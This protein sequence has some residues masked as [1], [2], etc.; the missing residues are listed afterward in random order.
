MSALGRVLGAF[1]P[2]CP[3][4][5]W[6]LRRRRTAAWLVAV[7]APL[8]ITLAQRVI[9]PSSVPP[10]ADLFLML[11]A[12]LVAALFGGVRPALAAV[13]VGLLAQEVVFGFPYASLDNHVPAQASVLIVWVAI[14]VGIGLLVDELR[15]LTDEQEAL[16]RIALV[17]AAGAVPADIFAA[18]ATELAALLHADAAL[19]A[20][21]EPDGRNAI[22]ATGG[23]RARDLDP[24]LG[25]SLST[26][27]TPILVEG[28]AW[29]EV[30]ASW[31]SEHSPPPYAE[32]R[33]MRFVQLLDAAIANADSREQLM[34]SRARLVTAADEARRRVVRD[35]HDG[36]QQR[37]VHVIGTLKLAQGAARNGAGDVEPL[38]ARA[39]EQAEQGN[40]E[41]RDLAHGIL[42]PALTQGGLRAGVDALVARLDLPVAVDV[43]PER[44]SVELEASGYFIVCEG[45]TNVIK[46]SHATHAGVKASVNDGLLQ[47]E[48]CDDGIGVPMLRVTAWLGWRTG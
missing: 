34:A 21:V 11:L 44:L 3:F 45:L 17:V 14:G 48:V 42:P 2:H 20:H 6:L 37:L 8:A 38:L 18:V 26:V 35:L 24:S 36:A 4:A 27:R 23:P 12:T 28:N 10:V 13:A 19:I 5:Q 46:H 30:W 22:V 15:R 25:T 32:E 41:L 43:P 16:R 29:G 47:V 40:R 7:A 39:L 33:M 31:D 9:G 1:P